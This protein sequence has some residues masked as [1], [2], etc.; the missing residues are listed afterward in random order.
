MAVSYSI[1][2]H[3]TSAVGW[4]IFNTVPLLCVYNAIRRGEIQRNKDA[5][6]SNRANKTN[7]VAF[8]DFPLTVT[9]VASCSQEV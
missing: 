6:I 4:D 2:Y 3:L 7:A 1:Q 9:V 8:I 5:I